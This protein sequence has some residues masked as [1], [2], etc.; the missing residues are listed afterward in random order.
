MPRG[1]L[2]SQSMPAPISPESRGRA[3]AGAAPHGQIGS[4]SVYVSGNQSKPKE[5]CSAARLFVSC[6]DC[7]H[8]LGLPLTSSCR[9]I[10]RLLIRS[11]AALPA[12]PAACQRRCLLSLGMHCENFG[13]ME[14]MAMARRDT[15][16]SHQSLLLRLEVSPDLLAGNQRKISEGVKSGSWEGNLRID[17]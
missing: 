2:H 4:L 10:S 3:G 9:C 7:C 16:V 5:I 14:R 17:P 11:G 6:L 8:H 15:D 13:E 1:L 12:P